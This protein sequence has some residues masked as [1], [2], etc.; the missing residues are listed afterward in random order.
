MRTQSI[1]MCTNTSKPRLLSCIS[2]FALPSAYFLAEKENDR[3]LP[4]GLTMWPDPVADPTTGS[5]AAG[6]L[7]ASHPASGRAATSTSRTTFR[8]TASLLN[9]G[10]TRAMAQKGSLYLQGVQVKLGTGG[11]RR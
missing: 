8:F 4:S 9:L 2:P 5:G 10:A 6:A 3:K 1:A 7:C 11:A